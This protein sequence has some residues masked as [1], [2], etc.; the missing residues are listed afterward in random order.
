MK[1][2]LGIQIPHP[3]LTD[4]DQGALKL[5]VDFRQVFA[6]VLDQWLGLTSKDILGQQFETLDIIRRA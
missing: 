4:L 6:T 5:H 3:S 2:L 1:C